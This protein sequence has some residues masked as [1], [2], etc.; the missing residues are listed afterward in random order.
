MKVLVNGEF[1]HIPTL[2]EIPVVRKVNITSMKHNWKLGSLLW[3][4]SP[5]PLETGPIVF[6]RLYWTMRSR[7]CFLGKLFQYLRPF[8]KLPSFRGIFQWCFSNISPERGSWQSQVW[9][10]KELLQ[11]WISVV[12]CLPVVRFWRNMA[13]RAAGFFAADFF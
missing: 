12:R 7:H 13:S 5:T 11:V 10:N 1:E 6:L 9:N 2:F 8:S 4:D 3:E